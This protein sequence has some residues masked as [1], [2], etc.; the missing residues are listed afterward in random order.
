MPETQRTDLHEKCVGMGRRREAR[1]GALTVLRK[2]VGQ[3]L[4]LPTSHQERFQRRF[5]SFEFIHHNLRE[6]T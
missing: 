6:E 3:F 2:R 5:R 1:S 4:G